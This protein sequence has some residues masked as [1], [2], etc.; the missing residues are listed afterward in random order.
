VKVDGTAGPVLVSGMQFATTGYSVHGD[1]ITVL[2]DG[3]TI[4]V[5]DGTAVGA[6]ITAVIDSPL[7]GRGHLTKTDL[8]TLV[9]TSTNSHESG[10]SIETGKVKIGHAQAL[11]TGAVR[12]N[13][14][15][16]LA[17]AGDLNLA[18]A[19]SFPQKGD[20]IIDTEDHT[21][22]ISGAI[23]RVGDLSK[24]GTGTLVLS[25]ANT[26]TGA[27]DVTAGR[28]QV[29]GSITSSSG[30]TVRGGASLGGSGTVPG[31]TV[32]SGATVAPGSASGIGTL[33]VAGPVS[34]AAG[35]TYRVRIDAAG[36]TDALTATGAA[37][38]SGGTVDVQAGSGTYAAGQGYRI[39]NASAVSGQFA[40]LQ[41]T[42]NLAFLQPSLSYDATG[43][44]L[45]F[46]QA[47]TGST[48]GNTV[49]TSGNTVSTP[50]NTGVTPG[51]TGGTTGGTVGGGGNA[52]GGV[53]VVHFASVAGSSN[54]RAAASAVEALG[55]GRV[56]A[57]VLSQSAAGAR[58]AFD[59]VSGEIHASALTAGIED[60]RVVREA[61][62]GRLDE[63]ARGTSADA[64]ATSRFAPAVWGTGFGTFGRTGSD[65]NA[66]ALKRSVNGFVLGADGRLD[67]AELSA[68]RVGVA[69]GYTDDTLAVNARSSRADLKTVF[70]GAYAGA[71]LGS[72]DVKLGVMGGGTQ[73]TTQRTILF[74]GFMD[75]AHGRRDGT[76]VQ[77]FGEVGYRIGVSAGFV[78]PVVQAAA[79]RLG[80]DEVRE[81]GG[82][83]GLR[84][85]GRSTS[86]G[87]TTAGVRGE[88]ALS[89]DL[90]L[91]ARWSVGWHHAYGDVSPRVLVAFGSGG[92]AFA[93][94]GARIDGDAVMA[95]A[96]LAYRASDT[97]SLG[98]NYAAQAG[99]HA[100]DQSVKGNVE[101]RF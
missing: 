101:I 7:K 19:I 26:Y 57:A 94:S 71:L 50:G 100:S 60:S 64:Q 44:S 87:T 88:L 68:W 79:I 33:T 85:L 82:A 39:L 62:T 18:N 28:L 6:A 91:L 61:I 17:F 92:S 59:A 77:G 43:V 58:Q 70:G 74:P 4:R 9:L 41:T 97:V 23:S 49:G 67:T 80:Q 42:T 66:A 38:L 27:T 73:T 93:V 81:S 89:P 36:H 8:G 2:D 99:R 90:P 10:T 35:S 15:T 83:A 29:D 98:V 3:M 63:A 96:G 55:S 69:G 51:N 24:V 86:V 72:V 14:G 22:T 78:A 34:F 76:I 11:G 45:G 25:G 30:V 16:T 20:P 53:S 1:A 31:L 75:T 13:E 12:L 56:Y 32:L 40:T 21:V 5:G 48:S 54:Q 84:V 65:G 37:T 46:T 47:T 52:G 95:E